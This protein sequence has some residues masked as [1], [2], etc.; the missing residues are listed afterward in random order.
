MIAKVMQMPKPAAARDSDKQRRE[1]QTIRRALSILEGRMRQPGQAMTSPTTAKQYVRLRLGSLEREVFLVLFLDVANRVIGAEEMFTGTLTS[2]S[3]YPREIVKR[4]VALNAC[5][6][7][8][9]HNHPSGNVAP[10]EADKFLTSTLCNALALIDVRLLD[11]FI[12]SATETHSMAEY[13]EL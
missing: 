3:V 2:T 10:S 4:V 13:G 1:D 6:V 5:S 9:A 11:H 8:V 12:T 7:M